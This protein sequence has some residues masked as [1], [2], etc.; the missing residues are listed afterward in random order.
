MS[1]GCVSIARAAHNTSRPVSG[2]FVTAVC[3]NDISVPG[4]FVTAVCETNIIG[5]SG[6]FVT[7]VC[8]NDISVPGGLSLQYVKQTTSVCLVC[9]SLGLQIVKQTS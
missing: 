9:L 7:V 5:V 2:G 3:H 6:G 1:G 8:H 4:G